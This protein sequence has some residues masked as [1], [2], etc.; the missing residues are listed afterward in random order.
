MVRAR[1]DA[2]GDL[3]RARHRLSKLLL[4][5]GRVF[6][7]RAWT[8]AHDAWLRRQVFEHPGSD[9]AFDDYYQAV[10]TIR[11][12]RDGLDEKIAELARD[13]RFA[14]LVGR[15]GCLRG[16]GT[17]TAFALCVEIGDWSRLTG[18]TI[19]SYLGLVPS[20]HQSGQKHTRGTITKAGNSHARRL[21]VEAAWH[22]RKPHRTSVELER[23]RDG[24]RPE[25]RARAEL[26]GRRLH[27]RWRHLEQHRGVRSTVVAVA[28]ARELAGFCW[29]LA[30]MDD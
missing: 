2:R 3:M 29:S 12:R 27:Q 5:H 17:L 16:V 6:D 28:V 18:A 4:R 25:V 1:E 13:P 9:A 11:L 19:G 15:L 23:R 21:L 30:V 7:G 24:Q 8:L 22:H 26:A 14:P 20:E 10:L